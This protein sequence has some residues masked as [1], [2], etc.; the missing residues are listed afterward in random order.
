MVDQPTNQP[1]PLLGSK[2]NHAFYVKAAEEET[3]ER[4]K[5]AIGVSQ[6]NASA[7]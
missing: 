3:K 2:T 6:R 1:V 7:G 5:I 4:R